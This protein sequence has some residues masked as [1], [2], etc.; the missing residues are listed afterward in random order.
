M[1]YFSGQETYASCNELLFFPKNTNCKKTCHENIC[2]A[3][4]CLTFLLIFAGGG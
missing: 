2:V 4:L 1:L 3:R